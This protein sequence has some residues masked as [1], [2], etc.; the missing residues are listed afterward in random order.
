MDI[1][2][3]P[4]QLSPKMKEYNKIK[5]KIEKILLKLLFTSEIS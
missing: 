2:E 1:N 4:M 3:P 5:Y